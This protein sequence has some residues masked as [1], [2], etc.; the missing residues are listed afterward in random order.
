M[1][2]SEAEVLST[3]VRPP[4]RPALS[5]RPGADASSRPRLIEKRSGARATADVVVICFGFDRERIRRQPWHVA[6]GL[7]VGLAAQGEA[8]AVITDAA[9]PPEIEGCRVIGGC[10]LF[11]GGRPSKE[12]DAGIAHLDPAHVVVITGAFELARM[13]GFDWRARVSL[14]MASP[15]SSLSEF[16][17]PGLAALWREREV[18]AR[19]LLNCLLPGSLLRAGFRRSGAHGMIYLSREAQQRYSKLGLPQGRFLRPQVT[20]FIAPPV[21]DGGERTVCYLG[22]PLALRGA[23]LAIEAFEQAVSMGLD[24]RLLMLL[25]PDVE[26]RSADRLRRRIAASPA[27]PLIDCEWHMLDGQALRRRLRDCVAFI[28][29][30]R[31]PVSEVPLVVLE[32]GLSGRPVV[33]LSAPGVSEYVRDLGGIV[34]GSPQ[35]LPQALLHA[36]GHGPNR[37]PDPG[38]W[39]GWRAAVEDLLPKGRRGPADHAFIALCGVDGSG[40]TFLLDHLREELDRRGI[41]HR[42]VWSRFRNYLSKP[43]LALCRLTGHNIRTKAGGRPIGYHE[44]QGRPWIGLPFLLLQLLDNLIDLALRYRHGDGE[45]VVGDRC[46][47]DTLVDLAVDTGLDDLVIERMGPFLL[48]RLPAP[49]LVVLVRR[50]PRLVRETRPDA[51]ADKNFARRRALYDRIAGRFGLPVVENDSNPQKAVITIL[52]LLG[53]PELKQRCQAGDLRILQQ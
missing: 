32:A 23:D 25:R 14:V 42:H 7:A 4:E 21:A 33:A 51:L 12:L 39:R 49:R 19:P 34:V 11:R 26:P 1:T 48:R 16:L 5:A 8:V 41:A 50:P 22:P 13:R 29:P 10:P 28:L 47:L 37:R 17:A 30:F 52:G 36:A 35:R 15:R 46:V 53:E 20:P 9:T 44:F 40:K 6:R 3:R 43:F 31:V 38:H 24:C 18:A 2:D 45:L 27:A